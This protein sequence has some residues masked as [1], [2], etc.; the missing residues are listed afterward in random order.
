MTFAV[1]MPRVAALRSAP[2]TF[3]PGDVLVEF[4]VLAG[5]E[6]VVRAG[7]GEKYDPMTGELVS[8]TT[9]PVCK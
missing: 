6:A 9:V 4:D 7:R 8:T 2:P 1:F 5:R 3:A